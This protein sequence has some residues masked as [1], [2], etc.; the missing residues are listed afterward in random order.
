MAE[1]ELPEHI[2]KQITSRPSKRARVV[3][4]HILER[5]FITTEE[6]EKEYGY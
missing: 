6:L 3:I 4:K 5:G 2:L 1:D